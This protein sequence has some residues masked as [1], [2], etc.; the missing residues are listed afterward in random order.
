MPTHVEEG[1]NGDVN[2]D[3]AVSI[4]DLI[5]V[6]Q[7]FGQTG[8]HQA[9]VN[10]D[11]TVDINDLIVVAGVLDIGAAPPC[12]PMPRRCSLPQMYASGYL[13]HSA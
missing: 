4:Q 2:G 9:D 13:K 11:G 7:S 10:G 8:R 5:L 1:E 3:G 6:A 12:I